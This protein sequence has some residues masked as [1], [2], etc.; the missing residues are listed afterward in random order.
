[1]RFCFLR[2]K[3]TYTH[4]HMPPIY[5]I[6]PSYSL[7]TSLYHAQD[8]FCT[9]PFDIPPLTAALAAPRGNQAR[10]R[11][12]RPRGRGPRL[13]P[14]PRARRPRPRRRRSRGGDS[15]S[16]RHGRRGGAE[17]GGRRPAPRRRRRGPGGRGGGEGGGG[18]G[19]GEGGGGGELR[20]GS[21][22]GA[23][24]SRDGG[25]S[26]RERHSGAGRETTED[27]R[28]AVKVLF[29]RPCL[30]E[31][32]QKRWVATGEMVRRSGW[33]GLLCGGRGAAAA[34]LFVSVVVRRCVK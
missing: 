27:T 19:G 29:Q 12:E 31:C 23:G 18:S 22:P 8:R 10:P 3:H 26:Q 30:S 5:T 11:Q 16:G 34:A 17:R 25:V 9:T 7:C 6:P 4:T 33:Q 24:T 13:R 14:P 15:E 20:G 1:M 32:R 2:D 28:C 21:A